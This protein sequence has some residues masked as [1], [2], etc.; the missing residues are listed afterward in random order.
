MRFL[1][2]P[3]L[4][5]AMTLALVC[6]NTLTAC[7]AS[8]QAM[9]E[10]VG[11]IRRGDADV[12]ISGGTHSMIHPFGVTGFNRLT[13]LSTRNDTCLT[14]SR[15]FDRTRDGYIMQRNFGGHTYA[16]LAH[17]G[18]RT[19]LEMIRT[20]QDQAVRTGRPRACLVT[21]A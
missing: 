15:P 12:M 10:A 3:I 14:A 18:D 5:V 11:L 16:R 4:A 6:A 20:L 13:A 21:P 2:R 17:V 8:T 1:I 7:A 9:G 19:G